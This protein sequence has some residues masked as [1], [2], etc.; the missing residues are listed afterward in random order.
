VPGPGIAWIYDAVRATV[1]FDDAD[2]VAD[3]IGAMLDSKVEGVKII[4]LKNR[5]AKALFQGYRDFLLNLAV[6]LPDG[7]M[8]VC[9][10]QVHFRRIKVGAGGGCVL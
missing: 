6:T 7:T 1:V 4:K 3:F 2:Q 5:S 8:H 10:L 9:E